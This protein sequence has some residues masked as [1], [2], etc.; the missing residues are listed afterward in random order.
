MRL[1]GRPPRPARHTPAPLATTTRTRSDDA[2]PSPPPPQESELPMLAVVDVYGARPAGEEDSAASASIVGVPASAPRRVASLR[3]VHASLHGSRPGL[4]LLQAA[5]HPSSSSH[6]AVLASDGRLRLYSLGMLQA[7]EQT[8]NL[9]VQRPSRGA[10][11]PPPPPWPARLG[12]MACGPGASLEGQ[13]GKEAAAGG[14]REGGKAQGMG[15]ASQCLNG[16]LLCP[17]ATRA[18]PS[19]RCRPPPPHTH[20]PAPRPALP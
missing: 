12:G 15:A 6:F 1:P 10:P 5:W 4:K 18:G 19:W 9:R 11:P 2:P 8:F 20:T 3:P 14:G 16:Q 17:A 7:A 13:Q